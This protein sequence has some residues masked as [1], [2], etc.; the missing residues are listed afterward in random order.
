MKTYFRLFL[1][2]CSILWLV[3]VGGASL[4]ASERGGA[5]DQSVTNSDDRPESALKWAMPAADVRQIMGQ[6]ETVRPLPAPQ[7]KAEVW[8]FTRQLGERVDR[9]PIASVPIMS[10]TYVID[11]GCRQ[12]LGGRAQEQKVGETI[13]YADLRVTTVE[14]VEV[15]MFNEHF[16]AHKVSRQD[17]K[18]YN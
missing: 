15:L 2:A 17:V 8:V 9:V 14:T 6:P 18:R 16:V 11:G 12:R 4:S 13:Q 5:R 7:G 10:T 1:P 3:G